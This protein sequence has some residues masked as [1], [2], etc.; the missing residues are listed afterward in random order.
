MALEN[1]HRLLTEEEYQQ[2]IDEGRAPEALLIYVK[3]RPGRPKKSGRPPRAE[4]ARAYRANRR[5][6]IDDL[7]A[8]LTDDK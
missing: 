5:S 6:V 2:I 3:K 1:G 8:S 4:S 7:I